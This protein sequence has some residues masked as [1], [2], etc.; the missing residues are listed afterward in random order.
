MINDRNSPRP[1]NDIY[2]DL[3]ELLDACAGTNLHD[4]AMVGISFCID[5]GIDQ[6]PQ[7]IGALRRMGF[8]PRHIGKL[9]HDLA[10]SNPARHRWQRGK[11]DRYRNLPSA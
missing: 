11:D 2:R 1:V 4:Q 6:G 9:L 8:N 7:I 3:R 10:G 5:E